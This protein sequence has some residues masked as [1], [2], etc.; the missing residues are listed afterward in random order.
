[1]DID[2]TRTSYEHSSAAAVARFAESARIP[3]LVLTHFSARY[4][5]SPERSPSI[6]DIRE[7]AA[8]HFTGVL[9]LARD[10]QRYHF[11][12]D[13]RLKVIMDHLS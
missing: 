1:M 5:S 10:L 8:A 6:E 2:R 9:I 4:Q 11:D 12:R 13:G 7:E 3:N